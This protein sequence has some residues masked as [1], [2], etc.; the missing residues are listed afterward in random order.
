MGNTYVKKL[1]VN[2]ADIVSADNRGIVY[3][4]KHR[5]EKSYSFNS[6]LPKGGS[7]L[8]YNNRGA[9]QVTL[10]IDGCEIYGVI[11]GTDRYLSSWLTH[12]LFGYIVELGQSSNYY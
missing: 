4:N 6:D 11:H 3:G 5:K 2:V 10:L 9:G 8:L 12:T 1:K 7:S